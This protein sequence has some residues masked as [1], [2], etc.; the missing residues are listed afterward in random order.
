MRAWQLSMHLLALLLSHTVC[1]WDP[2]GP[3]VRPD[4]TCA[5][6]MQGGCAAFVRSDSQWDRAGPN[7]PCGVQR[8]C[9]GCEDIEADRRRPGDQRYVEGV[10]LISPK[11]KWPNVILFQNLKQNHCPPLS[12]CVLIFL[13][14]LIQTQAWSCHG[15]VGVG[16]VT[17]RTNRQAPTLA[18][19]GVSVTLT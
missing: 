11:A 7:T 12:S 19:R 5:L 6:N 3:L 18:G 10:A 16:C 8:A 14:S 2:G 1:P 15:G 17:M 9:T 13:I 4:S